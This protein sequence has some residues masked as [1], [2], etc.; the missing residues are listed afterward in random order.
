MSIFV[1]ISW[2]S[3]IV[4]LFKIRK[5][6]HVFMFFEYDIVFFIFSFFNSSKTSFISLKSLS[7]HFFHRSTHMLN[8]LCSANFLL[9]ISF[10]FVEFQWAHAFVSLRF[11]HNQYKSFRIHMEVTCF[12]YIVYIFYHIFEYFGFLITPFIKSIL[13]DWV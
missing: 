10:F 6:I 11:I 13:L 1:T 9:V 8:V 2:C 4:I 7:S 3:C 5:F 12:D